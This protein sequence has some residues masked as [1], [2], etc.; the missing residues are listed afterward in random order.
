MQTASSDIVQ[1]VPDSKYHTIFYVLTHRGDHLIY[2]VSNLFKA[3]SQVE[4]RVRGRIL[5]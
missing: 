3:D 1:I 5:S 4:C 2:E